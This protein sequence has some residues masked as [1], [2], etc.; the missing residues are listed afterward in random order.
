MRMKNPFTTVRGFTLVE[1]MVV[2]AIIGLLTSIV[3]L[4]LMSAKQKSRDSKRIADLKTI[5]LALS[6]YY[7]DNL[8][9]PKNI[10]CTSTASGC[11]TTAPLLGLAPTYLPVVPKDPN[12]GTQDC[13]NSSALNNVATNATNGGCYH[14]TPYP[15]ASTI[16]TGIASDPP[17]LYHLAATME[18]TTNPALAADATIDDDMSPPYS[19]TYSGYG[20][21]CPGTFDGD[22]NNCVGTTAAG[23]DNCLSYTP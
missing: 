7:N 19:S 17:T 14:Y 3:S 13:T 21:G 18:D 1:L 11:G 8:M 10:Y 4:G 9:Y 20:A 15:S 12:A 23:T 22:A 16:C 5:Q 6:L 2:I